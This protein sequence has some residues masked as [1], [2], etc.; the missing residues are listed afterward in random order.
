MSK[1]QPIMHSA[2]AYIFSQLQLAHQTF[3]AN[4][5]SSRI[6]KPRILNWRYGDEDFDKFIKAELWWSSP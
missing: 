5:S 2:I 6:H 4:L 3:G 1:F